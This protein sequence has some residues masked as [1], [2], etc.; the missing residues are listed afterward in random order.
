MLLKFAKLD[1][2]RGGDVSYVV[3]VTLAN[4]DDHQRHWLLLGLLEGIQVQSVRYF[5]G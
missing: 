4:V 5:H 1:V 2:Q 3:F